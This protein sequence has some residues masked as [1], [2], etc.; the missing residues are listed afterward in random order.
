MSMTSQEI[1]AAFL[2][3]FESKGSLAHASFSLVPHDPGLLTTVAGMV[4][5]KPY[6]V[7]EDTPP[8]TRMTTSQKCL[9][10]LDIEEVGQTSWH[11]TFFEM[12]GNFSFGD[13]FKEEAITWAWEFITEQLKLPVERL[14][15]TVFHD[16]DEAFNLWHRIIGLEEWKIERLGEKSNYWPANAPT[17]GPDGPCGPCSEIFVD[18]GPEGTW[19]DPAFTVEK[20]EDRFVEIWN[21]VFMQNLRKGPKPDNLT[22]LP[23]KNIDTGMGLERITHVVQG[24]TTNFETDLFMPLIQ[25]AMQRLDVQYGHDKDTDVALRVIA[26]HL[27]GTSFL[28][29]DGVI[30]TNEG[31]GYLLRRILRRA[32][33]RAYQLGARKPLLCELFPTLLTVMGGHYKEL[34]ERQK[35]IVATLQDEE[36]RFLTTL[37]RGLALFEDQAAGVKEGQA[38]PGDKAFLLYDTYGFPLEL[39]Q[40]LLAKDGKSVDMP[41]FENAM[42]QQRER[43]R[44]ASVMRD[45]LF[46]E[47]AEVLGSLLK[48]H[49]ET[50][51]T[52]YDTL[53]DEGRVLALVKDGKTVQE[54]GPGDSGWVLLDKTPC[55]G[56]S[57]GQVSDKATAKTEGATLEVF[58]IQK[59]VDKLI[60]H[61]V[62]VTDGALKV[63]QKVV[64]TVDAAHRRDTRNNHTATHLLH[65]ALRRHLGDHVQQAG[66]YVGPDKLRFDFSHPKALTADQLAAIED[67]VND[68]ISQGQKVFTHVESI[69]E[70]KARGAM[71]IFGEKYGDVVRVL[72]IPGLSMEFCGGTHVD[73]VEQI[74][75]FAFTTEGS[76]GSG[77]RRVEAVTGA[78]ARRQLLSR[79]RILRSLE[80]ELKAQPD[81]IPERIDTLRQ[82]QK[83][84][85]KELKR[86]R[87]MEVLAAV[88]KERARHPGELV[89]LQW[90]DKSADA[91]KEMGGAVHQMKEPTVLAQLTTEGD[92]TSLVIT[93]NKPAQKAGLSADGVLAH[94]K[95]L[96]GGKGG[97]AAAFAQTGATGVDPAAAAEQLRATAPLSS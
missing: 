40:E 58:D 8:A 66:S 34:K 23:K 41:G 76:I 9:R 37:E 61:G 72:D 4:P 39:T 27:R 88:E 70:A 43:A 15:V 47:N 6:F 97:G 96:F 68:A 22:P 65:A 52:G 5:L 89:V 55:Y 83:T 46:D 35:I 60:L 14:R 21:L 74:G 32:V 92:R 20:D 93:T 54:F 77:I 38:L 31:R 36:Q 85:N 51:F 91:L 45:A 63:D 87:P 75:L 30:P 82:E 24:T 81:E 90:K 49:G 71:M 17:E 7:G 95:D 50:H 33:M 29:A 57:G 1:R 80:T 79:S 59:A 2:S 84:L 94:V 67:D 3:F 42:K 25:G 12:L 10:A 19:N 18:M 69:D 28:I 13:Y 48:Q 26:D 64:V 16:D 56:E 73:D 78:E 11:H 62:H 44:A 86:L 53:V